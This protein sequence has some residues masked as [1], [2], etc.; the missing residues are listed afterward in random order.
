MPVIEQKSDAKV[1]NWT[2]KATVT[3]NC[4]IR[5]QAG[6]K[7]SWKRDDN[8][9]HRTSF[10]K[11]NTTYPEEQGISA[12]AKTRINLNYTNDR[13]IY[14]NFNCKSRRNN[15]RRLLCRSVYSCSASY[16]SATTSS[17]GDIPVIIT[18]DIGK[19]TDRAF[20]ECLN[21]CMNG[22]I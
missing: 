11:I 22:L 3:L 19:T 14:D 4:K 7:I 13:G 2:L 1:L 15:T 18:P 9:S 16:P 20:L 5:G 8:T 6:M 17:Q 10:E 21:H 12:V